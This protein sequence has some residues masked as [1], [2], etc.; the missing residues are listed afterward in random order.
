MTI[1]RRPDDGFNL[2]SLLDRLPSRFCRIVIDRSKPLCGLD[3]YASGLD[4]WVRGTLGLPQRHGVKYHGMT[5][6]IMEAIGITVADWFRYAMTGTPAAAD[7]Q[8]RLNGF[9]G[10]LSN[11][12]A[13]MHRVAMGHPR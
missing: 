2:D 3:E 6:A 11:N 12:P 8:E 7:L 13:E 1:R 10:Y 5:L 4:D 9:T